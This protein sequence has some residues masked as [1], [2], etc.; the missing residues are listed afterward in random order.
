[1]RAYEFL[2]E[3]LS[4]KIRSLTF[5]RFKQ[6]NTHLTDEQINY[7]LDAW[8]RYSNSPTFPK[9]KRDIT[10]LSFQ[11]VEEI[12]DFLIT[13]SE[14]KG[15]I[16]KTIVNNDKAIYN[17][18][19]LI[20]NKGDTKDRCIKYGDGFSFCISR[21]DA[22]NLFYSYRM[23]DKEP[24]FYFVR[25]LEKERKDPTDIWRFIVIHVN[26]QNQY[27]VSTADNP[28]DIPMKWE[29]IVSHQPKLANLQHLFVYKPLTSQER[30]D[31]EKYKHECNLETYSKFNL[32]EKEKYI[33][34]GHKLTPEQ[35][36]V[37]DK[38]LLEFY[39]MNHNPNDLTDKSYEIISNSTKKIIIRNKFILSD[40]KQELTPIELLKYYATIAPFHLS[41]NTKKKIGPFK[42]LPGEY[43]IYNNKFILTNDYKLISDSNVVINE[44]TVKVTLPDN[45]TINGDLNCDWSYIQFLPNNLT[46][47]GSASFDHC[48]ITSIPDDIK[49]GK[50]LYLTVSSLTYLPDNLTI[51]GK[52]DISE[53]FLD[54]LPRNLH[55]HDLIMKHME[56]NSI[57]I[58]EDLVVTGSLVISNTNIN[59]PKNNYIN[60]VKYS[61]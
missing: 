3:A 59:I 51:P 6:D 18:N 30:A 38:R 37:T 42:P 2:I 44:D 4:P 5:N 13:K 36:E 1:M 34:F 19:D 23:R 56:T 58:P 41:Q 7:Y 61:S 28:G 50:D 52:L 21:K 17:E 22:S 39:A 9:D 47:T 57:T 46:V 29:D 10:R 49:I 12:I 33:K 32:I 48:P 45:I 53:S 14:L 26:N 40:E 27:K 15:K 55:V 60:H 16:T 43:S 20:I 54:V 31:Y 8:N 24:V 25:D 11:Q 35:Q